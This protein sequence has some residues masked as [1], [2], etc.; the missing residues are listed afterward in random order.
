MK[1]ATRI[2]CAVFVLLTLGAECIEA[3]VVVSP[4]TVHVNPGQAIQFSATGSADGVYIWSLSGSGCAGVSCGIIDST[5][6]YTAPP[7]IPQP[8][9]ITVTATSLADLT[10]FGTATVTMGSQSTVAVT[11]S[12]TQAS[13][14]M[15]AHQQFLNAED[16]AQN[17]RPAPGTITAYREP[18]GLGVRVDSAAYQGWTIPEQYDSLI[19]KLV[20]WAPDRDGAIARLR[21][22]IDEYAIEGVPTTLPL[23]RALCDYAPV[24]DATYGTATLEPFAETWR[25]AVANGLAPAAR[26][27]RTAS[28]PARAAARRLAPRLGAIRKRNA[29]ASGNDVVAPMH[30]IIV[31]LAVGVGDPVA[32]GQVVAVIEAM[33]MMNE[34][35]THRSGTVTAIHAGA[36][37]SVESGSPLITLS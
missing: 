29:S 8:G 14:N 16:P 10:V 17:F 18:G 5:G 31:E 22:A 4:S 6:F 28:M 24:A 37:S 12:P 23:L 9:V 26:K 36:G 13:V 27:R 34:I 32:E 7:A 33:K 35:R 19:A 21:R 15:G 20:V 25:L 3:S 11:V 30:G 2:L 1:F